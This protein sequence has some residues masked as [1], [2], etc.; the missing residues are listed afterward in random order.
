MG[1]LV[2]ALEIGH[3]LGNQTFKTTVEDWSSCRKGEDE[4]VSLNSNKQTWS[5]FQDPSRD[6]VCIPTIL[7]AKSRHLLLSPIFRFML[8]PL[9]CWK[10][11]S[12]Y[13]CATAMNRNFSTGETLFRNCPV[14][15]SPVVFMA[16]SNC[17]VLVIVYTA[18][19]AKQI[20]PGGP[21]TFPQFPLIASTAPLLGRH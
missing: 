12:K 6:S 17:N 14:L 8:L 2:D 11:T 19:K 3:D 18:N 5:Y 4:T 16:I 10:D 21:Q 1:D 9:I 13:P 7:C 20:K 15:Y